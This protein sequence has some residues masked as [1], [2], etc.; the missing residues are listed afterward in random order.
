MVLKRQTGGTRGGL[1]PHGGPEG[2]PSLPPPPA[3][4]GA[5]ATR[6]IPPPRAEGGGGVEPTATRVPPLANFSGWHNYFIYKDQK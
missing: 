2:R 3:A 6:W 4:S 5:K 1:A